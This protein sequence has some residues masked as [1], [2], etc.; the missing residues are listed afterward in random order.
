[1]GY[2]YAMAYADIN[3]K[4]ESDRRCARVYQERHPDEVRARKALWYQMNK[5]RRRAVQ[6]AYRD[7]LRVEVANDALRALEVKL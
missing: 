7:S 5:E 4:R 6:K 3:K 2:F 1:M